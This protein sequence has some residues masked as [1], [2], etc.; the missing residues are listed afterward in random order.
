MNKIETT[1]TNFI[2]IRNNKLVLVSRRIT[3]GY[4]ERPEVVD[5]IVGS[6]LDIMA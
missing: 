4:Y 3:E 2:D 6:I 1:W 5:L